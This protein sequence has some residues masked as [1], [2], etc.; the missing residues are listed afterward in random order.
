MSE[1]VEIDSNVKYKCKKMT[2]LYFGSYISQMRLTIVQKLTIA[3]LS[4]TLLVLIATLSLARW[5]FE[6][7]FMDYVSALEQSRLEQVPAAI[8]QEYIN[9]GRNW[10]TL[11]SQRLEAVIRGLRPTT[12]SRSSA[13]ERRIRS[14]NETELPSEVFLETQQDESSSE[15]FRGRPDPPTAVYGSYGELIAGDDLTLYGGET[16]SLPIL[17]DDVIIGELR[18][19]FTR[20][21]RTAPCGTPVSPCRARQRSYRSRPKTRS[22]CRIRGP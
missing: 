7:G 13:N 12:Y 19:V 9:A 2:P 8:A 14:Q 21:R 20:Q 5:S 15:T 10:S 11:T 4:L 22:G 16:L 3:I 1:S 18:S 6:R 17:V